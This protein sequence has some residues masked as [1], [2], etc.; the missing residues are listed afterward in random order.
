MHL[1]YDDFS[2]EHLKEDG[3]RDVFC[4]E[5]DVPD[6]DGEPVPQQIQIS[7][8]Q[9]CMMDA[10]VDSCVNFMNVMNVPKT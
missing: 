6:E 10:M 3:M 1:P 8:R 4:L 2:W 5:Y 7:S 9:A